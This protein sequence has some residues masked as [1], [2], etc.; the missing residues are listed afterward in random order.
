[1]PYGEQNR[2]RETSFQIIPVVQT[3]YEG[4]LDTESDNREI[5]KFKEY[6]SVEPTGPTDRLDG[7]REGERRAKGAHVSSEWH[8]LY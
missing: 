8:G 1:M 4:D 5:D 2:I 6:F 3:R 7:K